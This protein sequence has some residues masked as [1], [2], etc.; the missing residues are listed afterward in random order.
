MPTTP[1]DPITVPPAFLP[2]QT[3]P[4]LQATGAAAPPPGYSGLH[5]SFRWQVPAQFNIAQVCSQRWAAQGDA[6]SRIAIRTYADGALQSAHSYAQLQ[7]QA[8]RLSNVLV[9]LG[10]RRG[11]RVATAPICSTAI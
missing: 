2:Q 10:V 7:D 3:L 4:R 11:D 8:N 5:S 6:A 1:S 9:S